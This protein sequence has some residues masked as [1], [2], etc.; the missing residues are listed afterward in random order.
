MKLVLSKT[1]AED[2]K[3]FVE[4]GRRADDAKGKAID[5]LYADGI[6]PEHMLAP[7]DKD[8]DRSFY[9]SLETAVVSGFTATNQALLKKDVKTL[10]EKQKGERRYWQQQIASK[11]KDMRNS[12]QRRIDKAN[13]SED[14]EAQTNSASW[15]S[16]KRKALTDIIAQAKKKESTTIKDL[17]KFIQ[18]LESALARI[19][20]NA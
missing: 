14:G 8:A 9:A 12:L 20:A 5:A 1:T 3:T 19:P 10:N 4:K 7:K 11:I 13:A 2:I 15:E 18:D 6:K 16:A 17:V